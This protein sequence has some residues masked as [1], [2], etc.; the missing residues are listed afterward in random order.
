MTS[1]ATFWTPL[2]DDTF[3]LILP[4]YWYISRPDRAEE[5]ELAS[6]VSQLCV[7]L[8]TITGPSDRN[9]I[10]ERE[11]TSEPVTHR[12]RNRERERES[13]RER[14]RKQ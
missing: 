6:S 5:E 2:D 3:A 4:F 1:A 8:R 9:G 10:N 12:E 14:E 13:Y 11:R 7:Q